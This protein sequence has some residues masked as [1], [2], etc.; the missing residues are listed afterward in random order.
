MSAA[1]PTLTDIARVAKLPRP[2]GWPDFSHFAPY[3]E[4]EV[5]CAWLRDTFATTRE[6][7]GDLSPAQRLGSMDAVMNPPLWE[8]AHLAWFAERWLLRRG[9]A[10]EL[11]VPWLARA[12]GLYNSATVPHRARWSLPFYTWEESWFYLEHVTEQ[13]CQRLLREPESDEV[14][15]LATLC[16]FHQ[17]MHNEAFSI[18]R[19]FHGYRATPFCAGTPQ[20]HARGD[21]AF[22]G[23]GLQLGAPPKSGFVFCNEMWAHEVSIAPFAISAS[24]V[25]V[26]EYMAFVRATGRALPRYWSNTLVG[27]RQRHFDQTRVPQDDEPMRH[28]SAVEAQAYCDWAQRR[29]AT[30]AEWEFAAKAGLTDTGMVWEW[31]ASTFT[32]YPGF[33]VG[34]YEEYSQPWFDGSYRV[35]RGGSFLTPRRMQRHTFRNFYTSDRS[36]M[37]CGFRTCAL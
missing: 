8:L 15:Y 34:P 32:P 29:L 1:L 18:H 9:D 24:P 2:A 37:F 4:P 16:V 31:T 20:G 3:A 26:G 27:V 21:I 36:D 12:D 35:L 28:V 19:Q 33:A 11:T 22:S 17:D 10:G 13:I 14:R 23:G 7:L 5:L 30:E 6:L 25:T